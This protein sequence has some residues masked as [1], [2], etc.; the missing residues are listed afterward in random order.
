MK[1]G[2]ENY[3][4][5]EQQEMTKAW[6]TVQI[7]LSCCGLYNASDWL[8]NIP[9]S[10]YEGDTV[11][12]KGCYQPVCDIISSNITI[13]TGKN[14]IYHL[15]A[16]KASQSFSK[17]HVTTISMESTIHIIGIIPAYTYIYRNCDFLCS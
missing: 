13:L 8:D 4:K 14:I 15:L 3:Y 6:D 1:V 17:T 2:Q 7:R 16:T 9:A 5:E 12:V 10:C 11:N